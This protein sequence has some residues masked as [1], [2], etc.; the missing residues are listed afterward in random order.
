MPQSEQLQPEEQSK[1]QRKRDM[2]ALQKMGE[3][4]VKLSDSQLKKMDLPDQ[5]LAAIQ[6]AK[7]ITANEGKRRQLQYIGK[8]MRNIDIEP[9]RLAL[10]RLQ[11]AHDKNTETFHK[12]E[13]W[14]AKLIEHGDDMLSTF[15]SDYPDVD[16]QQ[17]RQLIRKAQQDKK[18]DKNTGAE[19][20]LFNY[21]RGVIK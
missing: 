12:I 15:L 6:H 1:S 11:F 4:L 17:L 19:K 21:L 3:T 16:R 7:S 5:L 9:I 10:E 14:R 2:L 18:S 8:I 13:S 20:A